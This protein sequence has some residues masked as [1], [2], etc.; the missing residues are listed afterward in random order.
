V[1]TVQGACPSGCNWECDQESGQ[2]CN[3][4]TGLCESTPP[5]LNCLSD[6]DCY[7]G[8]TCS[9]GHCVAVCEADAE[10]PQG[11]ICGEGVCQPAACQ[12]REDCAGPVCLVCKNG[13]CQP[14]ATVCVGDQEC[15][16]GYHCNFGTCELDGEGCL[17]DSD[18]PDPAQPVCLDGKCVP[19][20]PECQTDADC[21]G[22]GQ[23]CQDGRCIQPGCT[24]ETCP[25]G[26]WCDLATGLCKE[27]CDS[28]LDCTP[29]AICDYA[30]HRCGQV[31]CCGG[32]CDPGSQVCDPGT[33]QCIDVCTTDTDCPAGTHCDQ[34][35][36]RCVPDVEECQPADFSSP[37]SCGGTASGTFEPGCEATQR[38][39]SL[40]KQFTFQ[41]VAGTRITAGL[42]SA[43]D[44][45][46]YLIGPGNALLASNDD[47]G[48]GSD[49]E[50]DWVLQAD[51]GYI[52]EATT[53]SPGVTG[54]FELTLTCSD[55]SE[56]T[57]PV[58]CGAEVSGA[59]SADCPSIH[60]SGAYAR[61][62]TFAGLAGDRVTIDLSSTVDTYLYLLDP[63]GAVL[64][65]NDDVGMSTDSQI[66]ET[67]SADGTYTIEATTL[68]PH[69]TGSFDLSLRCAEASDCTAPIACGEQ[70]SGS[71]TGQCEAPDRWGSYGRLY[72][73]E[74]SRNQDITVTLTSRDV[75]TYL[76]LLDPDGRVAASD[77]D[78]GSGSNSRIE[79]TVLVGGTWTIE[80]TTYD[81]DETGDFEVELRC[82]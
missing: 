35:T 25:Q 67:L 45:Y 4:D 57:E 39:G 1:C 37:I 50:I 11:Q 58:A 13:E 6:C 12:T 75:D 24:A 66:Q 41:G 8:E 60:R 20:Y 53:F 26:Q 7:A 48:A 74:A 22:A 81:M 43:V 15:C 32:L 42:S 51:G 70:I 55:E 52:L 31:D 14:P 18:C 19:W 5:P 23:V 82:D 30:T 44:T 69:R 77:D 17:A 78:G 64:A 46:L 33:C 63:A 76:Y 34:P 38:P 47:G 40:A 28:N 2:S 71:W 59:W 21:P 49:S 54:A 73:F 72:T 10:C 65:Y 68:S 79:G 62:Y 9:G 36:G 56:C 61:L 27:G 80:A 29:P 16:V 3:R